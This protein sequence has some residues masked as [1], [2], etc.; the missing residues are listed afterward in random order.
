MPPPD[1]AARALL[2]M[3]VAL[4]SIPVCLVRFKLRV[5][6]AIRLNCRNA[7]T[8][9]S[10][11]QRPGFELIESQSPEGAT[12]LAETCKI[13]APFQG[14]AKFTNIYPGRCPGLSP[15]APLGL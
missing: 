6:F 7:A 4:L 10:P 9:E 14:L 3:P 8:G 12:H 1:L 15:D 13:L 5:G 11:G 2:G